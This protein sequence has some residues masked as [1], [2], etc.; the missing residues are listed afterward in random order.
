MQLYIKVD[1]GQPQLLCRHAH[2]DSAPW[3]VR[4]NCSKNGSQPADL[5]PGW[6]MNW[7][8]NWNILTTSDTFLF[9]RAHIPLK[10]SWSTDI[11]N[12]PRWSI[13]LHESE[14]ML[15]LSD[16]EISTVWGF[17]MICKNLHE[18][19]GPILIFQILWSSCSQGVPFIITNKTR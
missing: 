6:S 3:R 16:E 7:A 1:Q 10:Y 4:V 11:V 13:Y 8:T 2:N 15:T 17:Q 19:I 18:A 5:Q 14:M 12:I 9:L